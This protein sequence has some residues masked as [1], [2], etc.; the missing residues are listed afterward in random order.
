G[1]RHH[2]V[3]RV[4][5]R[6]QRWEP[7]DAAGRDASADEGDQRNEDRQRNTHGR[8]TPPHAAL[9]RRGRRTTPKV[10]SISPEA[11]LPDNPIRP[12][13]AP[14]WGEVWR[15]RRR[16]VEAGGCR[17]R[18]ASPGSGCCRPRRWTASPP[19][20]WW[21]GRPRWSRNWWK[22]AW[23]PARAPSSSAWKT[24]AGAASRSATTA[25]A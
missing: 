15:Q 8:S 7:P 23:T 2:R 5:V 18:P 22:T 1:H 4:P 10:V 16:T 17:C 24:A 13:P 20:R 6:G 25:T 3:H 14:R 9:L 21:S 19:A 12:R 11:L